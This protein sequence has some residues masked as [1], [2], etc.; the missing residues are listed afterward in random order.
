MMVMVVVVVLPHSHLH[1]L[2]QELAEVVVA[3]PVSLCPLFPRVQTNKNLS[4]ATQQKL[5]TARIRNSASKHTKMMT[6]IT[7]L[8]ST[9]Y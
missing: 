3:T 6:V 2:P 7:Y 4:L 9:V 5:I 8:A 1:H